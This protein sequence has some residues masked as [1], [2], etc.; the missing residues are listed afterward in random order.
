MVTVAELIGLLTQY[1]GGLRVVIRGYEGGISDI[2]APER[3]EID[4][5]AND[6]KDWFF[7]P[8]EEAR[9]GSPA[10]LIVRAP[11]TET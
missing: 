7:G 2:T 6:A 5:N 3:I 8:H 1:P 10:V 4:L 9:G 11:A